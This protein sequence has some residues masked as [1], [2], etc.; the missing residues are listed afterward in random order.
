MTGRPAW[1]GSTPHIAY[2][3]VVFVIL[4]S[5]DN[6]AMLLLPNM[7]LP[8]AEGLGVSESSLGVVTASV[9]VITALTAVAWGYWG[10]RSSRKRLLLYGTLIWAIGTAASGTAGS[11]AALWWWQAVSAVGLGSIASVGFSVVSDFISPRRHA[12]WR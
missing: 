7:L 12:I 9:I 11:L 1:W 6:A 5:L 10:D 3:V 8:V 2:T 4:A